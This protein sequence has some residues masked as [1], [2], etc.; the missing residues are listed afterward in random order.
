MHPPILP[1]II[2]TSTSIDILELISLSW[3]GERGEGDLMRHGAGL[4]VHGED[5]RRERDLLGGKGLQRHCRPRGGQGGTGCD[6][7]LLCLEEEQ[8]LRPL[9]SH[10]QATGPSVNGS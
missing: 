7:V 10:F 1:A 4:P 6:G 9:E 2:Q 5:V 3:H 8:E